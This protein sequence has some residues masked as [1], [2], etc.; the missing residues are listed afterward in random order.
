MEIDWKNDQDILAALI[1]LYKNQTED[2]KLDGI[3]V[4]QN[5]VG[6][7][8]TDASFLTSVS[9]Q[10]LD[11]QFITEKQFES[12]KPLLS[13]YSKQI[14]L[15]IK[16]EIPPIKIYSNDKPKYKS[17][18]ILKIYGEN[19]QFIP[20]IYPSVQIKTLGFVWKG[21]KEGWIG[22]LSKPTI[23]GVKSLFST[24]TVDETVETWISLQDKEIKLSD[25]VEQSSLFTFQ[26]EC[27]AFTL[28][29]KRVLIA[30]APGLGKTAS[31]IFAANELNCDRILVISPLSL[32]WNWQVEIKRW[33]NEIAVS[34]HG[35]I[36]NWSSY[37]KWVITNYDTVTR[38]LN[39]IINQKFDIVIIDESILIKNRKTVR[40]RA[41][42]TLVKNIQYV[43]LLSGNPVSKFYDDLWNQ[44]NTLYSKRF[45]S[46]WKFTES[47]CILETNYWGTAVVGNQ[48]NASKRLKRDIGDIYFYRSQEDVLDIPDWIFETIEIPMGNKQYKY[49][50]QMEK[51]FLAD[52][53]DG[54]IVL[55]PI[56]LTQ[57][58]RLMQFASNPLLLE[59]D[60]S[61][62]KWKAVED[63]MEFVE[64]P[65]IIWTNFIRTAEL[66]RQRLSNSYRVDSLTGQTKV[67]DRQEIVTKFQNGELD[68]IVA[69]PGVG[70]FGLTLTK[71]RT[72]IYMERSFNGDDYYQSLYR[73][74][75]IGTTQSP[76]VINLIAVRPE[77]KEGKTIDHVVHYVLEYR[78][79][80]SIEIT[81]QLLRENLGK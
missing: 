69:H 59:G 51:E 56:V 70:K 54:D 27:V 57:L 7:N 49:Y 47:Y 17:S 42:K 80:K 48:E 11:K 5:K 38:N 53:P 55:A 6:F 37:D 33:I 35:N 39:D 4:Y 30:L 77:G 16:P 63:M 1:L 74:K 2:E 43:W 78:K 67:N 72:A 79:N 68:V 8:S 14:D 60:D 76:H 41:M 34:W 71:A 32:V 40:A 46:Y 81:S 75:R 26:K 52:L 66:M 9:Q 24:V 23:E 61:G 21:Q 13:K 44:L 15:G 18:G 58:L 45:G 12:V 36:D 20:Q 25:S 65:V 62:A 19:L 64:K 3:T 50:D 10:I 73:I 22:P 28:K 31:A 29:S